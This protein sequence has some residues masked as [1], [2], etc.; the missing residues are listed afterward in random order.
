MLSDTQQSELVSGINKHFQ[1]MY[2]D[3]ALYPQM[4]TLQLTLQLLTEA[5]SLNTGPISKIVVPISHANTK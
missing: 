1:W 3:R 5:L 2:I 4:I